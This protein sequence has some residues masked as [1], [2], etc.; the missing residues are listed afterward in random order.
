MEEDQKNT[1]CYSLLDFRFKMLSAE[2]YKKN[3]NIILPF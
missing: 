3:M 1:E 2:F